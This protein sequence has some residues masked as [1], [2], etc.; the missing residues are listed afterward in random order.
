MKLKKKK[1]IGGCDTPD[2]YHVDWASNIEHK[3][4]CKPIDNGFDYSQNGAWHLRT[5]GRAQL[6]DYPNID[7]NIYKVKF[8]TSL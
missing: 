8:T 3:F 6:Y 5:Q 2:F 1:Y 7:D 4:S